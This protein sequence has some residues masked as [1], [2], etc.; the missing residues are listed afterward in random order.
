V[1]IFIDNVAIDYV[2]NNDEFAFV[3]IEV[4]CAK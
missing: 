4:G 3:E 2:N 1:I